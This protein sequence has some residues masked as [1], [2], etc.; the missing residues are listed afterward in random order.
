MGEF[1]VS[2]VQVKLGW[3]PKPSTPRGPLY[4]YGSHRAPKSDADP[5]MATMRRES[6]VGGSLLDYWVTS[7]FVRTD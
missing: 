3:M 6:H 2:S 4:V 7:A 1:A 5:Q